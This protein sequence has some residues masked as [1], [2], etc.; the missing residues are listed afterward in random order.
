MRHFLLS[1]LLLC[2]ACSSSSNVA[3]DAAVST[4]KPY[5]AGAGSTGGGAGAGGDARSS[6]EGS[7]GSAGGVPST[8]GDTRSSTGGSAGSTGGVLSTG[9][10]TR[11]STGGSAGSTGGVSSAGGDTRSS[12][13]GS[14]G[15]VGGVPSAGGDT[16]SSAGGGAGGTGGTSG[17]MDGGAQSSSGSKPDAATPADS[18]SGVDV[19]SDATLLGIASQLQGFRIELPCDAMTTETGV[20]TTTA[21]VDKQT[22]PLALGGDP[23]TTYDVELRVRGVVEWMT[24]SG[25]AT[26]AQ[27]PF[28]IGGSKLDATFNIYSL[29]VPDPKQTYYFNRG[30][31]IEHAVYTVDYTVTIPM[32]GKAA[33]TFSVDGQNLK[34]MANITNLVVLEIPPAPAAYAGQFLQFDVVSVT[35]R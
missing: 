13:G 22:H 5:E 32:K 6:I 24:Y 10:D 12:A 28:C 29:T 17:A 18:G 2:V 16:R 3:A 34:E 23:G 7:A 30:A 21:T 27:A 33:L 1:S 26:S 4:G 9:G 8:G 35:A 31:T 15:S 25:C 14:A 11:S 20:C 19:P